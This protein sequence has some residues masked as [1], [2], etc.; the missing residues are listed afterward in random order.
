MNYLNFAAIVAFS[1]C[2]AGAAL[3]AD[4][5]NEVPAGDAIYAQ[6]KTYSSNKYSGGNAKSPIS[7]QT[8]VEAF[9]TCMWNETP[10]NFKGNLAAFAETRSG[11]AMNKT[12]EKYSNW[13]SD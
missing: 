7:G 4:E 1:F 8:K 5:Y 9:C 10:D 3:A 12:C 13:S 2:T 6:C 11:A